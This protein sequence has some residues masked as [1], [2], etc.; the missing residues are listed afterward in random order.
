MGSGGGLGKHI[1][2]TRASVFTKGVY[3]V[4]VS[5]AREICVEEWLIW[6]SF[7]N[8]LAA[9]ILSSASVFFV[10][11]SLFILYLR[12]NKSNEITRWL[13]SDDIV[14]CRLFH[15]FSIISDYALCMPKPGRLWTLAVQNCT[16]VWVYLAIS[17]GAFGILG[18]VYLL[19]IPHLSIF[20]LH[21]SLK[22]KTIVSAIFM[23][24]IM[25][26]D[27]ISQGQILNLMIASAAPL[28]AL[29]AVSD[30][31]SRISL[32]GLSVYIFGRVYFILE[33]VLP[34]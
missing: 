32:F 29:L 24:R 23:V 20:Q 30:T 12:L 21:L 4:C 18:D 22:R 5:E 9:F 2:E 25:L 31:E 26:V 19:V 27:L 6:D 1:W 7:Q 14:V 34:L 10:K 8:T 15:F 33:M 3:Q 17:R 16:I 13:V 28:Y 11:L